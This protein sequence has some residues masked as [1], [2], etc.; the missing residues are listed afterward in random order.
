MTTQHSCAF[1]IY[2]RA[3]VQGEG[4]KQAGIKKGSFRV[5]EQLLGVATNKLDKI[6]IKTFGKLN[7]ESSSSDIEF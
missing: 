4:D 1:L 7:Q 5:L 3:S 6:T 2:Y